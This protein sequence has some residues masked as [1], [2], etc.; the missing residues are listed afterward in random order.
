MKIFHALIA[1]SILS[2]CAQN[3]A[4]SLTGSFDENQAKKMLE[5]GNNSIKGS[6]LIR[7]QGGGIVTCAGGIV[8]L[9]PAT[10]YAKEWAMNLYGS[11]VQGYFQTGP[12]GIDFENVDKRFYTSV[13]HTN[14]NA[15]GFFEFKEVADGTF[16]VFTKINWH[17]GG[18]IQGGSIMQSIKT[19]NGQSY[20]LTLS[21]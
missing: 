13:R 18:A 5:K 16:Y 1:I 7:Q 8:L 12:V 10:G 2:G 3:R 17:A 15:A 21:P 4:I 6:A 14:C 11:D 19:E 20:E 9:M